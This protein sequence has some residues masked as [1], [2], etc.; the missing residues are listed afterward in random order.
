MVAS[1]SLPSRSVNSGGGNWLLDRAAPHA[2]F[3][4]APFMIGVKEIHHTTEDTGRVLRHGAL[5]KQK[6]PL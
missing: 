6:G 2:E 1:V 3:K 5:Y 4:I